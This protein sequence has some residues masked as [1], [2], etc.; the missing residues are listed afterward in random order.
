MDIQTA[1]EAPPIPGHTVQS[2]SEKPESDELEDGEA[3]DALEDTEDVDVDRVIRD[4]ELTR[5]R[6]QKAGE[7]AWRRL[8]RLREEKH[9]AELTSDFDDYD[10]GPGRAETVGATRTRGSSP[11]AARRPPRP[12]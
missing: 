11:G 9:T 4:L 3:D 5:R 6:G 8:E 2:M 10:V 1:P 12:R 7:P